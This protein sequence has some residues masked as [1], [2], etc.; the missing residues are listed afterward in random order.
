MLHAYVNY[1]NP[2]VRVHGN[3]ACGSIGQ[4]QK[5]G[6]RSITL[7]PETLESEIGR[8]EAGEH[9]FAAHAGSNDM[10]L[11]IDLGNA[12]SEESAVRRVHELL[13]ARYKPFQGVTVER[14]C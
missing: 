10:W 11:T 13:A 12:E 14:H 4:G 9:K 7:R 5:V 8:F 3:S 1:P 2:K 6:Q